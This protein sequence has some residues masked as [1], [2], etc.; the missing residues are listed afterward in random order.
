ME[1]T[2]AGVVELQEK[3]FTGEEEDETLMSCKAS[4]YY[5]DRSASKPGWKERGT[6]TLRLNLL[7]GGNSRLVMRQ[8]GILRLLLNAWLYPEIKLKKQEGLPQVSFSCLNAVQT[9]VA[10]SQDEGEANARPEV[11]ETPASTGQPMG[12]YAIKFSSMEKLRRF[13]ELVEKH[14]L[15]QLQSDAVT[16]DACAAVDAIAS[17]I[18]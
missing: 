10:A 16:A 15:P 9:E 8:A 4:L 13:C 12:M 6:G 14:K 1:C 2:C 11:D 18:V 3:Q 17:S 7:P 5:F